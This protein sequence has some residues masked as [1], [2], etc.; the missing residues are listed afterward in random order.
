MLSQKFALKVS[1]LLSN[2]HMKLYH[3]KQKQHTVSDGNMQRSSHVGCMVRCIRRV[4]V[5]RCAR[6]AVT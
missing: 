1:W 2:P 6:R 3:H 5:V 4:C